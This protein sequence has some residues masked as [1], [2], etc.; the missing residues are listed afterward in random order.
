MEKT[1][2]AGGGGGLEHQDGQ[3]DFNLVFKWLSTRSLQE[4]ML[5]A[6]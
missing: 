3:T 1:F 5:E 4:E 6:K 2:S